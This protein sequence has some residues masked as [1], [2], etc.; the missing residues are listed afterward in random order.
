MP[1]KLLIATTLFAAATL[2]LAVVLAIQLG[3]VQA[4]VVELQADRPG[5]D[6]SSAEQPAI[7]GA[8]LTLEERI[9]AMNAGLDRLVEETRHG[10]DA[11]AT[12]REQLAALERRESRGRPGDDNRGDGR[13]RGWSPPEPAA[14]AQ[15]LAEQAQLD[16]ATQAKVA[17]ML[18]RQQ[19]E[20][21]ELFGKM[22]AGGEEA[23]QARESFGSLR[24]RFAN[25]WAEVLEPEQVEALQAAMRPGRG[26]WG[27]ERGSENDNDRDEATVPP[28]EAPAGNQF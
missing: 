28:A 9:E 24:E 6:D 17:A 2:I 13:R 18:E 5:A 16:A 22:R 8:V 15:A 19:N 11:L 1:S 4:Q 23:Q 14:V 27:R 21:R 10:N 3:A 12:L 7:I 25:E 20:M 26:R